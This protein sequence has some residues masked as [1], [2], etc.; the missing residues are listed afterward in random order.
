[1]VL[2]IRSDTDKVFFHFGAF[3]ALLRPKNPKN[4]NFEKILKVSG[5]VIILHM[6]A[7]N[8]DHMMYAS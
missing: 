1:M 5:D 2:E 4:Q 8:Q 6:C 7:K 3:L